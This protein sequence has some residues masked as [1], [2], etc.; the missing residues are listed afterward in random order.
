MRRVVLALFIV[1]VGATPA[2]AAKIALR[3][4]Q[5]VLNG[6]TEDDVQVFRGIPFA[7]P[8]VGDLRWRAPQPAPNWTAARDATDFG[9]ICP[10]IPRKYTKDLKQSEDC[11]SLNVWTPNSMSS[12]KLPVMVWIYGGAFVNGGAAMPFYDGTDLAK[13]G[14]VIVSF[15]YRLGELGFFA[16][17]ALASEHTA[18]EATGNF[19][20]LDQIAALKWVQKNIASFGGDPGNV[21]IF[22]ESAGGMSVNDLVASPMARG[23][24]AKAISQSGLGLNEIP[25]L[26]KAQQA[27]TDW[28]TAMGVTGSDAD[29]LARLRALK[30]DDILKHRATETTEGN[31]AP[32]VDGKVVTGQVSILFAKG[33]IAKVP[34]IA[35]S[36]SNEASLASA[37]GSDPVKD[38]SKFGDALPKVRAIYEADGKLT[39]K[40]FGRQVFGDSL[41]TAAAQTLAGFADK[42][43]APARVYQFAYIADHFRG[44]APGVDHG[45]EIPFVFGFRGLGFL[46]HFA[47]DA[48]RKVATE[49]GD[50]WTN[51]AK[52]GN[53]NGPGLTEWPAF[54]TASQQTLVIDDTTK[55]VAD[56]RKG[57]VG[58]MTA[59]WGQRV[60][61]AAP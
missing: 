31:I 12:A 51:F 48:D 53:P 38:L 61:M 5:G 59:R 42:A 13:R 44:H 18:D 55:A 32:F 22:G 8:P 6:E 50:Y 21:T 16:H 37:I 43:G 40:E 24:F 39:D 60:G 58:V 23:L 17:P 20:L 41:F 1:L 11:L 36:N 33:D 30:V 45:G 14:V 4:E 3:I 19:G 7:A 57:Q 35:G 2:L 28:G 52:T 10:Q 34:Y 9:P 29:A 25:S 46:G 27:S 47:S 56:F 49:M 26:Q 15:N 54:S